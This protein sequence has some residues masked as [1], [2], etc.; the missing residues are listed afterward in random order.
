MAFLFLNL[1]GASLWKYFSILMIH[2]YFR[3]CLS[4]MLKP[5]V[6][7]G[8]GWMVSESE[9]G[10]LSEEWDQD[11][12][13]WA[14]S[15]LVELSH[16]HWHSVTDNMK[17]DP[18]DCHHLP[19]KHSVLSIFTS[20]NIFN[21]SITVMCLQRTQKNA[22]SL[23]TDNI[24]WK[25]RYSF[26]INLCCKCYQLNLSV[27]LQLLFSVEEVLINHLINSCNKDRKYLCVSK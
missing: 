18:C 15:V 19:A 13:E 2:M 12:W 1:T 25:R 4:G 14:E 20:L 16:L 9:T 21:G 17:E 7:V 10:E 8:W 27:F 22:W 23:N 3:I 6:C 11:Q 26:H 24:L 5:M